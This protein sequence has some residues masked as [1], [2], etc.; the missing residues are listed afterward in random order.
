[1]AYNAWHTGCGVLCASLCDLRASGKKGGWP[2][3]VAADAGEPA[4]PICL[5]VLIISDGKML[6]GRLAAMNNEALEYCNILTPSQNLTC[7]LSSL[8]FKPGTAQ[9]RRV[10]IYTLQD[11]AHSPV[12]R[13]KL[14]AGT[15]HTLGKAQKAE[16]GMQITCRPAVTLGRGHQAGYSCVCC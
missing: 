2:A 11:I 3:S 5:S 16:C 4:H 13:W 7:L 14:L 8:H 9:A 15:V 12:L 1:M 10:R 6:H